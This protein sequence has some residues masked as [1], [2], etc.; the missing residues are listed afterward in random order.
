MGKNIYVA[1]DSLLA[2]TSGTPMRGIM[3]A[4]FH[5]KSDWYFTIEFQTEKNNMIR[6]IQQKWGNIPNVTIVLSC[7]Y[8]RWENIKKIIG[9]KRYHKWPKGYDCYIDPGVPNGF[10]SISKPSISFIADLSCINLPNN[11]SIKWYGNWIFKNLLDQS[12]KYNSKIVSIS[13]FTRHELSKHY[14]KYENKFVT[15]H[16]GIDSFWFNEHYAENDLTKSLIHLDYWIWWGYISN[17]KNIK[18]LI[19]SYLKAK[20]KNINLPIIV[21]IGAIA[22]NQSIC[23][24]YIKQYPDY[25]R[26]YEFQEPYILKTIVK[27]SKGLLFPSLYEGFGLP[28]IESYSQGLPVLYSEVTALP[29]IANGLGI[30]VNPYDIDSI[31]DGLIKM[32]QVSSDSIT[33]AKRKKWAANFNYETSIEKLIKIMNELM[34]TK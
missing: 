21:F 11:S 18:Y 19:E 24:N 12:V 26:I 8:K 13:N 33:I 4:L 14:P 30:G 29:E 3:N 7:N 17:R 9:I 2:F 22:T 10:Y 5:K 16:N 6:D 31:C 1:G 34:D 23:L 25:F 27:N 20:Q 15:I 28:V 32:T